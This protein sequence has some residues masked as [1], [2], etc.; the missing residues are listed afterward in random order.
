MTAH[1]D[2]TPP[3]AS[4]DPYVA[5]TQQRVLISGEQRPVIIGA[6]LVLLRHRAKSIRHNRELQVSMADKL[7]LDV[8]LDLLDVFERHIGERPPSQD[9]W[10]GAWECGCSDTERSPLGIPEFCPEHGR[11]LISNSAG[12][13]KVQLNHSGVSGYGIH[14]GPHSV[15]KS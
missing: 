2:P 3:P 8:V 1:P 15:S 14:R 11:K 5:A 4:T 7:V 13:T 10:F 12:V 9:A 6:A